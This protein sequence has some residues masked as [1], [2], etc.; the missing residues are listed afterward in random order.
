MTELEVAREVFMYGGLPGAGK[1]TV[2]EYASTLT[3]GSYLNTGDMVRRAAAE[4]GIVDPGSE[5]LSRYASQGREEYGDGFIPQRIVGMIL[6]GDLEVEYPIHLDGI[7]NVSGVNEV[8][9]FASTSFLVYVEAEF[10]R[11]LQRLRDR[12]RDGEGDFDEIDLLKRDQ[13]E[14]NGLG[15]AGILE[16]NQIDVTIENNYTKL[17]PLQDE[18]ERMISDYHAYMENG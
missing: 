4:D 2:A 12:G 11:R 10:H 6:N 18:V 15:T 17:A 14:L 1:T 8:R 7:R 16:S 13:R 3:G 9:E 5:E